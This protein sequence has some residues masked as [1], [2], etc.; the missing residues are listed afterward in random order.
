MVGLGGLEPPPSSL[1]EIDSQA[2]CYPAFSQAVPIREC[3]R[4]GV[5]AILLC[6]APLP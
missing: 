2:L 1:S 5:Y 4:D 6:A 3:Y